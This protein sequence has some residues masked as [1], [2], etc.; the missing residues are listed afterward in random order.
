[1][2]AETGKGGK[3]GKKDEAVEPKLPEKP[4]F[5]YGDEKFNAVA[6]EIWDA[7]ERL[8]QKTLERSPPIDDKSSKGK[9]KK[10]ALK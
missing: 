1:M 10:K 2:T 4:D 8:N 6:E 9:K 5:D 3:K 7:R